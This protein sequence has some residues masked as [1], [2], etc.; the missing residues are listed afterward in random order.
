MFLKVFNIALSILLSF[1]SLSV[2]QAHA[3]QLLGLPEPGMMVNLSPAYQPALIKGVTINKDNP[4]LFDFI[5]DVGQDK[6]E[7]DALKTEGEKL[8]K[9]FLAGLAIPDKDLWVNLSPYEKDRT[10]PETLS[11]TEMGRDLLAQDYLLKQITA[12]LI[13]PEKDLGKAF[14]DKVYAKAQAQFGTTD[15]PVNTFNKVWIMADKAEVFERNQTAFVTKAHLKVMLEEDYL[16]LQKN[17][18]RHQLNKSGAV[19]NIS[20]Q[21][22]KEIVL[23]ELE[24]EINEGKNFATLRQIYNSLILAGWYKNNLKEALINQVYADKSKVNGINTNDPQ[25][26]QHIYE[27]Y[28]SAYK[29]G[30][31]NYIKDTG[32][33]SAAPKQP[34][35]Y[36]AG[37]MRVSVRPAATGTVQDVSTILK[38]ALIKINAAMVTGPPSDS[39][40][41]TT[42]E[43]RNELALA[44]Q[45]YQGVVTLLDRFYLKEE[46][47]LKSKLTIELKKQR[48]QE[49]EQAR[50]NLPKL[51]RKL[52]DKLK[53]AGSKEAASMMRAAIDSTGGHPL[54]RDKRFRQ[55]ELS[56]WTALNS[57]M[58]SNT[59]IENQP[60]VLI[61]SDDKQIGDENP[62]DLARKIDELAIIMSQKIESNPIEPWLTFAETRDMRLL[63]EIL[64]KEFDVQHTYTGSGNKRIWSVKKSS[65]KALK[66]WLL[67]QKTYLEQG[68]SNP[69]ETLKIERQ[70]RFVIKK[71]GVEIGSF[72][73]KVISG[74]I[75][76]IKAELGNDG[77]V[78]ERNPAREKFINSAEGFDIRPDIRMKQW[79]I[80]K[81]KLSAF[82]EWLNQQQ[83][84][85]DQA[86][87]ESASAA[88][89][90]MTIDIVRLYFQA[91]T[92]EFERAIKRGINEEIYKTLYRLL[93]AM[94]RR[95]FGVDIMLEIVRQLAEANDRTDIGP[96][97][98]DL[99]IGFFE[100]PDT[101]TQETRIINGLKEFSPLRIND[102]LNLIQEMTNNQ[103]NITL[104]YIPWIFYRIKEYESGRAG[105]DCRVVMLS[106]DREQTKTADLTKEDF[107]EM[108]V[109]ILEY[110]SDIAVK[111]LLAMDQELSVLSK[112]HILDEARRFRAEQG[113][114]M[115]PNK[116]KRI[117][118][119]DKPQNVIGT[120]RR[121][122]FINKWS[123]NIGQASYDDEE[124][125][126]VFLSVAPPEGSPQISL[127]ELEITELA[128]AD[129]VYDGIVT[130]AKPLED[131]IR[132]QISENTAPDWNKIRNKIQNYVLELAYDVFVD[133]PKEG[134]EDTAMTPG[135]I[136]LKQKNI[137]W[138]IHKEGDGIEFTIDPAIIEQIKREGI[139]GLTPVIY[140]ITPFV[141]S[142]FSFAF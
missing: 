47:W 81:T 94:Q 96:E 15:I 42:L 44:F 19:P 133:A 87:L 7:G 26:N 27:R 22:I 123:F 11:Q 124:R 9:Y 140:R 14:W 60:R 113:I 55:N 40:D 111:A 74:E 57:A 29:K 48:R 130:K 73:P 71:D 139:E 62:Q 76:E 17:S 39:N 21:I 138:S 64:P 32:N 37:G 66:E 82:R 50:K 28:L 128:L 31:F 92:A 115:G 114:W 78:R 12:S 38:R 41:I 108:F 54:I 56:A 52:Y 58:V 118:L 106:K 127:V 68:Q 45:E 25:T 100:S 85:I 136:D 10:I 18:D 65:A 95:D 53:V 34:R 5:V 75:D 77:I 84:M 83:K 63:F 43:W 35:K 105:S 46:A 16:A 20:S 93:A 107:L 90:A 137:N 103:A 99:T 3:Q 141:A 97:L 13:Y 131:F 117:K 135:G 126:R 4:F 88:D 1:S 102:V 70:P 33:S 125:E 72:A 67:V 120:S 69:E 59:S 30:V 91:T 110:E 51:R 79:V 36:F 8:I 104:P 116:R 86:L 121:L 49:I 61:F 2:P 80:P 98:Q 122:F 109:E 132:R 101:S 89:S 23:P 112:E 119:A 129:H 6:M 24:K 134:S 142:E